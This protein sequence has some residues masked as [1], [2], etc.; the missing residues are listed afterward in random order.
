MKLL[1]TLL[2]AAETARRTV[3]REPPPLATRQRPRRTFDVWWKEAGRPWA[4]YAS[5]LPRTK[6]S[7]LARR[8]TWELSPRWGPSNAPTRVVE[9]GAG[10]DHGIVERLEPYASEARASTHVQSLLFP[11]DRYTPSSAKAWA[12]AHGY[13]S[14]KVDVTSDYVRI[15]QAPPSHFRLLRTIP[16]G[17]SGIKAVVGR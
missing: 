3:A 11:R 4:L 17:H 12:D 7:A 6:A 10:P 1:E 2:R 14:G 8:V 9:H 5:G 16:F 15:R 13:R